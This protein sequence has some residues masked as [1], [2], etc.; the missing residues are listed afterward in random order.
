MGADPARQLAE[1][2][3]AQIRK[4][5]TN[6][7]KHYSPYP[8]QLKFHNAEG[9]KTPGRPAAHRALMAANQVGKTTCAAM[10]AAMHATGRYP[11]WWRGNRIARANVGLVGGLTNESVRD[12]NQKELFGD[13]T[14]DNQLGFGTIPRE[15]IGKIT[16][17]A[18]VPNAID[19][20]MVRHVSGGWSK[21]SFRAYEQGPKKHMGSRI[22]WGWP[23]EEPPEDI[24]AQYQR[25]TFA[26]RGFLFITFTPE[27]GVT[28]VVH[29]FIHDLKM[30]Q[31]LIR[32]TWDDAPHMNHD[33]REQMLATIP[34]HQ[35]E[36]RTKGVP[37]M[38]SGLVYAYP[39]EEVTCAPIEIPNWWPRVCGIDFGID[40]GFAALWLAW[41]RDRDIVYEIDAYRASGDK[42]SEHVSQLNRRGN[43]IPVIWPHDGLNREKSS[44]E[45]LAEMYRKEGANMWHEQ[46]SNPPAPGVEEGKGGNSVEFGVTDINSRMMTKRWYTFRTLKDV[47][48]EQRMYHRV[49]GKIIKQF[50]DLMDARRYAALSLRHA[51]TP[52]LKIKKAVVPLGHRN[53]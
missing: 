50:D 28:K 40:H 49:D 11:E 36:M 16:R 38:G 12:I 46:F 47:L 9:Y 52:I 10:E 34:S 15:A 21:I 44:G 35:R 51:M 2:F 17:K 19:S 22:D 30:G 20:A 3:A 24:W 26:T 14:D 4:K 42:M 27:D 7:L 23:D 53:W 5:E 37:L 43:W 31:A 1:I 18:G 29:G 8:Y 25:G 6:K 45:P 33:R 32:A 48:E 13:P 39:E 41:D